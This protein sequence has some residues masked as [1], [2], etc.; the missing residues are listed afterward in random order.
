MAVRG[1]NMAVLLLLHL[2]PRVRLIRCNNT[3]PLLH[4]RS[5]FP[6]PPAA[7]R[8]Q[9]PSHHPQAILGHHLAKLHPD[10]GNVLGTSLIEATLELYGWLTEVLL[11]TPSRFHYL[12]NLRDLSRVRGPP[13]GPPRC[14]PGSPVARASCRTT[15]A[16]PLASASLPRNV[17]CCP[18][19]FRP[20]QPSHPEHPTH[21]IKPT[22]V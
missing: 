10:I 19:T 16:L 3:S 22:G 20:L 7:R 17:Y 12:F 6:P 18:A 1:P 5:A 13:A 21:P 14:H 11:P 9:N 8:P 4:L 2:Q 15:P